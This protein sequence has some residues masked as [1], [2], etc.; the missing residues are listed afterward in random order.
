M[1]TKKTAEAEASSKPKAAPK[2][3]EVTLDEFCAQLSQKDRRVSLIGGFHSAERAAKRKKDRASEYRK[4]F[5]QFTKK[6]V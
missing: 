4:R 2:E 1:T 3:F 5:E 6:P